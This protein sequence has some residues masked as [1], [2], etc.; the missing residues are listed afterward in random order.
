[1]NFLT[2][3]ISRNSYRELWFPQKWIRNQQVVSQIYQHIL[4]CLTIFSF[5]CQPLPPAEHIPKWPSLFL[6]FSALPSSTAT[7]FC[8]CTQAG[9]REFNLGKWSMSI[10]SLSIHSVIQEP[11]HS[12]IF[13]PLPVYYPRRISNPVAALGVQACIQDNIKYI[14]YIGLHIVSRS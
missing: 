5:V 1:M 14:T 10:S 2:Q 11:R 9:Y 7:N 8:A 4:A 13:K 12:A 3:F 6:C